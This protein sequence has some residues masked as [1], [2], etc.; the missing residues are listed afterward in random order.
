MSLRRYDHRDIER[1]LR[2]L[3]SVC[4][5]PLRLVLI[6]G[7]AVA[8]HTRTPSGT[9]DID[10]LPDVSVDD[11][12]ARCKAK[13]IQLPPIAASAVCDHPWNAEDRIERVVPELRRLRVFL[14]EPHDLTLS[15]IIRWHAGD[16]EDVV[17]L[18]EAKPLSARILVDRYSTEM[19]HVMGDPRRIARNF[20]ECIDRLFGEIAADDARRAIRGPLGRK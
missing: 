20:I 11:L 6:G 13:R 3:D 10:H 18:H 19:S 16:E 1:A 14:L 7:A 8:L 15:K 5:A 4:P 12:V 17:E 2:A 9:H